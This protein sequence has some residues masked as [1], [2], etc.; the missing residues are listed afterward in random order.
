MRLDCDICESYGNSRLGDDHAACA[1]SNIAY[2][3]HTFD[4]RERYR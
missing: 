1:L 2:G 3:F 4:G